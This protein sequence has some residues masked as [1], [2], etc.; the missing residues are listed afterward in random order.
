MLR[1]VIIINCYNKC[2]INYYN[3]CVSGLASTY[4]E[5]HDKRAWLQEQLYN[6]N[7]ETSM[8]TT[9]TWPESPKIKT[10]ELVPTKLTE[11]EETV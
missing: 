11:R 1:T 3:I 7:Y 6:F 8:P 2:H 4:P 9:W 10:R 5:P